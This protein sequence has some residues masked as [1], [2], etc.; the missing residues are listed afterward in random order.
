MAR[1]PHFAFFASIACWIA[2][3]LSWLIALPTKPLAEIFF[4]IALLAVLW[5]LIN[6]R[7]LRVTR[8]TVPLPNLPKP[9]ATAPPSSSPTCTSARSPA[10]PFMRR[11]LA[12]I[13]ALNPDIVF[14]SGDLFDGPTIGLREL[15]APWRDYTA[16]L[17]NFYVTGNHD[18]FEERAIYL[19][20][21]RA[22]GIRVLHNEAITLDGLD[23]VGVTTANS[24]SPRNCAKSS[25]A[26]TPTAR[27]PPS[28]S[29]IADQPPHR[30]GS[31]HLAPTLRPHPSRP[32][33]ALDL[34]RPSHL[35]PLRLRP[36]SPR[37]TLVNTSS[38]AGTWGPPLRVATKSEIVGDSF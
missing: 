34:P 21:V 26:P 1:R 27:A 8:I 29:P 9:G 6:A 4:S 16:P 24:A 22:T 20:A 12:K 5:G 32:T 11:V 14:I 18:E 31:R 37:Q 17:G 33:L 25:P 19:D 35:R 23:L 15:D 13:R 2:E 36:P 30:R 10:R 7:W 3:G 38:G 28:S